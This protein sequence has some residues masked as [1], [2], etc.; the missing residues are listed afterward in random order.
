MNFTASL[1]PTLD[2]W[3]LLNHCFYQEWNKGHLSVSTLGVYAREYYHHV[4][5]FPRYISGIH[6]L[7]P[8]LQARQTLLENLTEE[9]QG[10]ENHPELWLR[11]AEGVGQSREACQRPSQNESTC[12]LVDG[13]FHLVRSDYATGLGALYAYERQTPEVAHSKI[14]GLKTHYKISDERTLQFFTVHQEADTW[15]RETVA[16]LLDDL[17][18]KDQKAA[19]KG[20]EAGASLLWSFLDSMMEVHIKAEATTS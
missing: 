17:S 9:E 6:T 13:F 3:H 10:T 7:C 5:A 1:H 19:A 20:A 12:A 18:P 4:A 15:H 14:D 2:R 11:F 16:K 8:D